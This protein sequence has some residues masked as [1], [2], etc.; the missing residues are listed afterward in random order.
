MGMRLNWCRGFWWRTGGSSRGSPARLWIFGPPTNRRCLSNLPDVAASPLAPFPSL[1]STFQFLLP[2]PGWVWLALCPV[3]FWA[4]A[5]QAQGAPPLQA[6]GRM[7]AAPQRFTRPSP[8]D[9]A[10]QLAGSV[11]LGEGYQ[12]PDG[13]RSL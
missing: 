10:D 8:R 6:P 7:H 11:D 4:E 3:L 13:L 1:M 9:L 2:R 12:G 5:G